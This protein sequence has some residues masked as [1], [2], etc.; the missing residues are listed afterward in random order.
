MERSFTFNIQVWSF[1][2]VLDFECPYVALGIGP[3]VFRAG[4]LNRPSVPSHKW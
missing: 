3:F 1:G 2:I 4:Q